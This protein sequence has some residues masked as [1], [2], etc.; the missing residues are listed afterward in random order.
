MALKGIN[1]IMQL[2]LKTSVNRDNF[3]KQLLLFKE[4]DF[5]FVF[6]GHFFKIDFDFLAVINANS[7]RSSCQFIPAK[8]QASLKACCSKCQVAWSWIYMIS[9]WERMIWIKKKK[10]CI[11]WLNVGRAFRA[12]VNRATEAPLW[13]Y[14]ADLLKW[15]KWT[16]ISVFFPPPDFF[17]FRARSCHSSWRRV[18]FGWMG[19]LIKGPVYQ[20]VSALESQVDVREHNSTRES[21]VW[22][23]TPWSSRRA[24]TCAWWLLCELTSFRAACCLAIH[25]PF[26]SP[27]FWL[28][29]TPAH[30]NSLHL[31]LCLRLMQATGN[32]CSY[33]EWEVSLFVVVCYHA[34]VLMTSLR[35]KSPDMRQTQM[36]LFSFFSYTEIVGYYFT[37]KICILTM[38]FLKCWVNCMCFFLFLTTVLAFLVAV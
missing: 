7:F 4:V 32:N 20:R 35:D 2:L 16:I 19:P 10:S 21:Y 26:F 6:W 3:L 17:M 22:L 8:Q 11:W 13:K 27:E 34:H 38:T 29:V 28:S 9:S 33:D 25:L 24:L 31:N 18:S 1:I 5:F 30:A 12:Y 15:Q 23:C 37:Y 14:F 36:L